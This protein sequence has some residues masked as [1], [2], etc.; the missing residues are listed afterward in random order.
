[1]CR[2]TRFA[3]HALIAAL[4]LGSALAAHAQ[5]LP[6]NVPTKEE[7]A[8]D[9]KL[10]LTLASKALKW[11]EPTEPVKIAGPLYF[12]GTKGLG[13]YLFV[14]AEGSILFNTGMPSS[15]PM[16]VEA[17]RTLGFNPEAI[18]VIING[19]AHAD[20]AGAFA[21]MKELTGATIAI[22]QE[23]VPL[24]EDGGKSDFH[25]GVDWQIMGQPPVKVDRILRDG[26]TIKMGDV[27]LTAHHTPG[28]TRG[29]TT[30]VANIVDNGKAYTVVWPDGGGF[31]PG[32]RVAK[33]P[34]YP[35][36]TEDYRRTHHIWEMLR[37][38]IF[39]AAHTEYFNFED[40]QKRAATEGVKA[41]INPEEYRQF[42]ASKK[43]AFEDQVDK[44][45]GVSTHTPH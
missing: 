16:I 39:L 42:V 28:H 30:W 40:K 20:H 17:I 6:P 32:Y 29:S 41:W 2:T 7:L 9:N 11:E 45:M 13:A 38:D 12:V 24:I 27:L 36:I 35:G 23:D 10:F 4:A 25:Y 14:T 8:K 1:M 3:R 18:K 15:G 33:N 19:H 37:P 22:M 5:T 21:Y 44:E 31:N 43:R 34:S 26:D